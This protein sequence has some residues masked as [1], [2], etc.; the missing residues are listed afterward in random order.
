M[1]NDKKWKH[2]KYTYDGRDSLLPKEMILLASCV[3]EQVSFSFKDPY[4]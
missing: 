4:F 1:R 3:C 2:A